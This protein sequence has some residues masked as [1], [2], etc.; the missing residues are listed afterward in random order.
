MKKSR[1]S[2]M[3]CAGTGCVASG[4]LKI[5]AA[6][7]EEIRKRGL[8]E[9]IKVVMTGCNG[10]CAEGPVIEVYPDEVFYQNLTVEEVPKLVE[11]H[12]LKGRPYEKVMFKEPDK[13]VA[14]PAM[15]DI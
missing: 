1:A 5:R 12:F 8:D 7:E 2:V 3:L 10:Y 9:E 13:K 4:S 6:F 15:K 14:I 11:E